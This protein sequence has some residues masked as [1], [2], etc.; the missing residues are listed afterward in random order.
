[1]R[2]TYSKKVLHVGDPRRD[3]CKVWVRFNNFDPSWSSNQHIAI[4]AAK[5][6][7]AL[8]GKIY[9]RQCFMIAQPGEESD[10]GKLITQPS[11]FQRQPNFHSN[12]LLTIY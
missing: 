1:M 9:D 2:C 3:W 4:D 8:N 5:R 10:N 6:G 12:A 11:I 7:R